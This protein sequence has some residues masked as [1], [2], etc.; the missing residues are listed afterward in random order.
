MTSLL[1][2][3]GTVFTAALTWIGDAAAMI[4]DQPLFIWALGLTAV[5]VAFRW[6]SSLT[7]GI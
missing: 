5:A 4:I 1:G 7:R 2:T 3:I 6:V